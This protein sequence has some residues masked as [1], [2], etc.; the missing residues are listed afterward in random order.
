MAVGV[1]DIFS[2]SFLLGLGVTDK[3]SQD[4]AERL[5]KFIYRPSVANERPEN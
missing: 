3:T 4:Q 1:N 5:H 2:S